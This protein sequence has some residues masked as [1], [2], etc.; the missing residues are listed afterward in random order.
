MPT[1]RFT[2]EELREYLAG[3]PKGEELEKA[4][5][6]IGT[7]I[8]SFGE[9]IQV[10]IFPNRP[11]LL[12]VPG[13]AR[14]INNYLGYKKETSYKAKKSDYKV[15]IE[16]SVSN[17]RP[18]TRCAVIK[19]LDLD[20]NKIN[21]IIDLQEKIHITFARQRKKMAIGVYPAEKISFPIIYKAQKAEKIVFKPLD[22]KKT[23]SADK[24]IEEHPTGK[25]YAHLLEGK[26]RYPVFRDSEDKVLS[27]PPIINSE[28]AGR[29]TKRTKNIFVECSGHNEKILEQGINIICCALKD[30]GGEIYECL[31]EYKDKKVIS[32]KLSDTTII[33]DAD[34]IVKRTGVPKNRIAESLNKMGLKLQGEKAIIPCYRTDFLHQADVAEEAA[35]G[36][37]YDNI[38]RR[39]PNIYTTGKLSF[40]T[41]RDDVIRKVLC[42]MKLQ[43]VITYNLT[44]EG[45]KL[46]NSVTKEYSALRTNLLNNLLKVLKNNTSV[47]YPQYI[48]EIGT[49][50][51]EDEKEDTMIK[52]KT[53][54]CVVMCKDDM[55]FTIIRQV[56][57]TVIRSMSGNVSFQ[58]E[59]NNYFIKGRCAKVTGTVNGIIGEINPAVL[60]DKGI[61]FP[62][63]AFE[64][65]L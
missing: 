64:I 32:P 60:S 30:M 51:S 22:Y 6:M 48:F 2:Q 46:M 36:Y 50:F 31:I 62:C 25:K 65:S 23:I 18:H 38:E 54:L 41:I 5:S 16:D 33:I 3:N 13:L 35:I 9:E 49:V 61:K 27:V 42:G 59:D 15:I 52:E 28:E 63:A 12:S 8:D 34:Y 53:N 19:N 55:T 10:E 57:E 29:V 4:I 14:A 11:D 40:E 7:D 26:S 21:Q 17:I 45:I 20:D 47:E 56:L 44:D 58:R 24:L 43:E 37:G 1:I 39:I